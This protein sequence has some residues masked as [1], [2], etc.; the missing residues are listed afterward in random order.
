[1]KLALVGAGKI[2]LSC[3]DALSQLDGITLVALCVRPQS[4]AK[5]EALQQRY[6]IQRLYTDYAQLLADAEVEV[7]YLGLPNHLHFDY[8]RAALQ[9]GRHVICE[10]PFTSNLAQLQQLVTLAKAQ[11]CFLFEAITNLHS[12]QFA[13]IQQQL[14]RFGPIRL[15]Q[16]NYSQYSSRYDDYLQGQ[17]HAAF[18]PASS[19]GALYDIN[20]Y[21]VYLVCGLFGKPQQV[22]YHCQ[23]GHNGIDTSGVLLLSYP[24]FTAVCCGAKD[25]ASPSHVT[26]QGE[27]GYGRINDAPNSCHAVE[28]QVAGETGGQAESSSLNQMVHEFRA[29]ADCLQRQD[30]AR[31]YAWLE[32]A[33]IVAEVLEQGRRSAGIRFAADAPLA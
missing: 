26:I 6:G 28:W 10:K 9:A 19:G 16:C 18:D 30:L 21:N 27:K 11:Q 24:G 23:R 20:L 33:L 17:V 29:F 14:P 4:Q 8:T 13:A 12:P 1:M 2:V 22:S 3:L 15:V 5:G 31:C 7:V 32:T 25:S